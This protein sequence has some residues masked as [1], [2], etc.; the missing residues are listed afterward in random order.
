MKQITDHQ[1]TIE[2]IDLLTS[3]IMEL[4]KSKADTETAIR[5]S[6]LRVHTAEQSRIAA[7]EA[8]NDIEI[9]LR[10]IS[11]IHTPE[12]LK[13]A[14]V[15]VEKLDEGCKQLSANLRDREIELAALNKDIEAKK[16]ERKNLVLNAWDDGVEKYHQFL[17]QV[18]ETAF[19]KRQELLE[20]NRLAG[21]FRFTCP[22]TE[23][24]VPLLPPDTVKQLIDRWQRA[25]YGAAEAKVS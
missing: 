25:R 12:S 19:Q 14:Q 9:E 22:V 2:K 6:E 20:L 5:L 18:T 21:D 7:I 15:K 17:Q 1:Q 3:E 10:R 11:P 24:I 23:A 8:V 13:K 16:E 4:E